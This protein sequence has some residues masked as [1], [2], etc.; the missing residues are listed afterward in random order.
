M[1]RFSQR[2]TQRLETCHPDLIRLFQEVVRTWDCTVLEGHRGRRAQEQAVLAGA[3]QVLWPDGK[4]NS[5]PSRAV[6]VAPYPVRFPRNAEDPEW[7]RWYAFGGFV[8]GVADQMGI[9]VRWGLDWDRDHDVNDQTFF[10]GPHFELVLP[11]G[12]D[13]PKQTA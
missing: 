2:S 4:H 5:V 6:D 10:D 13:A 11:I 7:H 12:P 9:P 3:S 1:P 8:L